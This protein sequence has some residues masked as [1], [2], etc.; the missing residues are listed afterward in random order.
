MR[1]ACT[2]VGGCRPKRLPSRPGDDRSQ[3]PPRAK[4][5]HSAADLGW[6]QRRLLQ[7]GLPAIEE[8]ID[9]RG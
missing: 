4:R 3:I 2:V 1:T 7:R 5:C 8:L 9:L 6:R